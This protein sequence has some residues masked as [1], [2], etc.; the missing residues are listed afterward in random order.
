MSKENRTALEK[1]CNTL[2]RTLEK[3]TDRPCHKSRQLSVRDRID[4]LLDSQSPFLELSTLAGYE[5]YEEAELPC[6]GLVTGIG[7][8][9][10]IECMVV[11]NDPTVK[12]GT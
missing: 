5:L 11:A 1:Q 10:G 7:L 9:N 2:T 8:I 3:I 12:G 4:N 6:G